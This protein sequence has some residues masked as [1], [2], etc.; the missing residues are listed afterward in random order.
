MITLNKINVFYGKS[1]AL[2]EI[3]LSVNP[4]EVVALIGANGAG[5]TTTLK[6][7]SGLIPWS[8]GDITFKGDSLGGIKPEQIAMRG[9]SHVPERGGIFFNMTVLENLE[10]GSVA[11]KNKHDLENRLEK[12]FELF[13]VLKDRAGLMGSVLSGG[14]RQMLAIGRAMMSNP[15][16]YL[17]DEPTL[18]LSPL[19]VSEIAD[20]ITKISKQG[21]TILLVEQNASMALEISERGYVLEIGRIIKEGKSKEL[22]QDEEVKKSYLGS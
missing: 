18:G 12:V 4:G 10:L 13:P 16:L 3:A 1:Q 2:Y 11:N 6:A 9:I 14:E 19:M 21:G 20:I 15:D 5:K 22:L 7:I 17:L 8:G